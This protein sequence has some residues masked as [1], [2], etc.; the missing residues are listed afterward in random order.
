MPQ[1]YIFP[2][3]ITTLNKIYLKVFL[4]EFVSSLVSR[5][6]LIKILYIFHL[7]KLALIIPDT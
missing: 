6:L 7:I 2:L 1:S 4:S 5:Y 3:T